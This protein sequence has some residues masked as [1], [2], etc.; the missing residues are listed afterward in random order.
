MAE[1]LDH[2]IVSEIAR[3]LRRISVANGFRTDAG[4]QVV[5]EDDHPNYDM[6]K[7]VLEVIDDEESAEYQT[8]VRRRAE[9]HLNIAVYSPGVAVTQPMRRDAR[10]VLADIRQALGDSTQ[11]QFPAGVLG[12]EI[13]GRT[14][15]TR[16][17]GSR[18]FRPELKARVIFREN[19]RSNP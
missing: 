14:F 13:G 18:L 8:C 2:Q 6:T 7:V 1:P 3:L 10:R 5:D 9:L 16:E 12:L 19:H 17:D 11:H 15:F 4:A